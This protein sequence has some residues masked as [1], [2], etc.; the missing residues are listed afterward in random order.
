MGLDML[1]AAVFALLA[2]VNLAGLI[3]AYSDKRK[4][5]LGR[6]R[7][8][9]RVFLLLALM[10]GGIG[11]LIGFAVFRHKTRHGRLLFGVAA[12]SAL[13]YGVIIISAQFL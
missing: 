11:V 5:R 2:A 6:W 4:A 8:P 9:E 1:I 3:A 7:T 12:L 10:G 13:S